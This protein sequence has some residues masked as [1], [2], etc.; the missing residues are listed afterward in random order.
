MSF[1]E[2]DQKQENKLYYFVYFTLLFLIFIS[3]IVTKE[4]HSWFYANDDNANIK[5]RQIEK[6]SRRP[7]K[8]E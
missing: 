2:I 3:F 7:F 6:L 5:L 1:I 4:S 8:A